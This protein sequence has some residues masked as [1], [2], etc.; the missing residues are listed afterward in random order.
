MPGMKILLWHGWLLT[1]SGSNV[2]NANVARSWRAAGHDVLLVCQDGAAH[3]LPFVDAAGDMPA[4]SAS[5][6]LAP[7][8]AEPAAGSCVVVRPDIG[9]LLPVFVY[10][11]YEGFDVKRFVDLAEEELGTY[12][13]RNV[14]AQVSLIETWEPEAIITGHE[15]MGP[16]IAR[17]ACEQTGTRYL[18]K[19]HGSG[20]EYAVK[21]QT[22]YRDLAASG[23]GR[24]RVVV[25]GSEYMVRAAGTAVPGEWQQRARV[26]NPGCDVRLFKPVER[27]PS[28]PT[29]GFVGK[30]IASKGVHDLLAA[31]GLT[32]SALRS[33][34]VG[35]GGFENELHALAAAL[36]TGDLGSARAIAERDEGSLLEQLSSFLE[37]PPPGFFERMSEIEVVFTGRLEHGPLSRALPTFD[38]LVV[39]SIVPEAFGMV[40]AEAA[41]CGVLPIVPDHSGIAEAG[42]A[43]EEAIGAP[44]LLTFDSA[45]PIRGI[46]EAIDRVLALSFSERAEMGR[47]AV[48]LARERWSWERVSTR[49]LD[50]ARMNGTSHHDRL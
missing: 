25:G 8:A 22:R 47:A 32:N 39:P 49:L 5:F 34:I 30:L 21:L 14:R 40:A 17:R 28:V 44:G 9:R 19:L 29:V 27:R 12:L 11:A 24:A 50:L 18:A 41:A 6:E 42:A 31:L 1:G 45:D 7:T 16:E 10:D 37:E 46:A 23:L 13:E 26:V 15:V 3:R 2:Y 43:V 38:V 33:V 35:Y 48:A 20:L 4:G 36:R